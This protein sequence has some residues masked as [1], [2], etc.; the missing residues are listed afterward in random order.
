MKLLGKIKQVSNKQLLIESDKE[1][2]KDFID[3]ISNNRQLKAH[4]DIQD[5]RLITHEQRKLIYSLIRD[6]S[7]FT[8]HDV[9]E[10]KELSKLRYELLEAGKYISFENCSKSEAT[11]FIHMLIDLVMELDVPLGR[12]YEYLLQDN[13]FFY[14]CLKYR[15]CCIC[16]K[17]NADIAHVETVGIGRDRKEIDHSKHHF[18]S[19]CRTHH[20]EQHTIGINT[21]IEKYKVIPIKLGYDDIVKLGL[22]SQAK[23]DEYEQ[24]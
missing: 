11:D 20:Q 13:Y 18:M 9:L 2:N 19:L 24:T 10:I 23:A 1:I 22:L 6:I 5:N 15:K 12:E 8:G 7:N 14:K 16:G 4:I 17:N 21:F 3:L